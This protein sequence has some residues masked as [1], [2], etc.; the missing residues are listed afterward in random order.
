MRSSGLYQSRTHRIREA[1]TLAKVII[2]NATVENLLGQKGYTVSVS[3]KD[4]S[5][6]EKKIYYKIWSSN[7]P[8]Q[9]AKLDKITGDLSVRLEEYTDKNGQPKQVAAIHVNNPELQEVNAPF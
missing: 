6:S 8:L 1:N 9:G 3:S 2:E 5:G 7:L 4:A